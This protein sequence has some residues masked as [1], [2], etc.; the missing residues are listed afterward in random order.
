MVPASF[1]SS[2]NSVETVWIEN[3]DQSS[4]GTLPISPGGNQYSQSRKNPGDCVSNIGCKRWSMVLFYFYRNH[5]ET[6]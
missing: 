5:L 6:W 4:Q 2:L 3:N 1:V